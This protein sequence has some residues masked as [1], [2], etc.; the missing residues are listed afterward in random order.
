MA[1][2]PA[3]GRFLD[4]A[5]L[6]LV[7]AHLVAHYG[8]K[9]PD[10]DDNDDNDDNVEETEECGHIES[11]SED[12]AARLQLRRKCSGGGHSTF[13]LASGATGARCAC[14]WFTSIARGGMA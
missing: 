12:N 3:P 5:Q 11:Q 2:T 8:T 4:A 13:T 9:L 7:L 10:D 14:G 1:S 6:K